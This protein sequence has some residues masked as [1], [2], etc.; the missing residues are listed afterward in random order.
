[1]SNDDVAV[2]GIKPEDFLNLDQRQIEEKLDNAV[3]RY[4]DDCQ[5]L[6]IY[7]EWLSKQVPKLGYKSALNTSHT[8]RAGCDYLSARNYDKGVVIGAFWRHRDAYIR[9]HPGGAREFNFAKRDI[10]INYKKLPTAAP[11]S[12]IA[13][14]LQ[15]DQSQSN[16]P[17]KNVKSPS[18]TLAT[19]KSNVQC[20]PA[21]IDEL[22]YDLVIR[23]RLDKVRSDNNMTF[24]PSVPPKGVPPDS[25]TCR[26]C[27][28]IQNCKTNGNPSFD[29]KPPKGYI[30]RGCGEAETHFV[31]ACP[32][33]SS[34]GPAKSAGSR[35]RKKS[36]SSK[37]ES[38]K[39]LSVDQRPRSGSVKQSTPPSSTVT[40]CR[41]TNA[42]M[43]RQ[44]DVFPERRN[45][46]RSPPAQTPKTRDD[47][48]SEDRARYIQY[49]TDRY[50]PGRSASPEIQPLVGGGPL[51]SGSNTDPIGR[52]P[53]RDSYR[54]LD[55][56]RPSSKVAEPASSIKMAKK[57]ITSTKKQPLAPDHSNG[58]A[59]DGRLSPWDDMQ[60]PIKKRIREDSPDVQGLPWDDIQ[61]PPKKRLRDGSDV[62]NSKASCT[63]AQDLFQNHKPVTGVLEP[64]AVKP[65]AADHHAAE[66]DAADADV[67]EADIM[68]ADAM[69]PNAMEAGATVAGSMEEGLEEDFV[70]FSSSDDY[71]EPGFD[72]D[73]FLAGVERD[74][75][76][77]SCTS[78]STSSSIAQDSDVGIDQN[79]PLD[80]TEACISPGSDIPTQQNRDFTN[81]AADSPEFTNDNHDGLYS[82]ESSISCDTQFQSPA[83]PTLGE[84]NDNAVMTDLLTDTTCFRHSSCGVETTPVQIIQPFQ[85]LKPLRRDPPYDRHVLGLFRG[86]EHAHVYVNVL[87]RRNAIDMYE[88]N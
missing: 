74:L 88:A 15:K 22:K 40:E 41:S 29:C 19:P 80:H 47:H 27:H 20:N 37:T 76:Y 14:S 52:R 35:S 73:S 58:R 68:E 30:C 79:Y 81:K 54:K 43:P 75:W 18:P 26:R 64:Y 9:N 42:R 1:M 62:S 82:L 56:Y 24:T 77:R 70:P 21:T 69:E 16:G 6:D 34:S 53:R 32:R 66:V 11:A 38:K 45:R 49:H 51:R 60:P 85:T 46:S 55:S 2:L 17:V 5:L 44:G 57:N 87:R 33:F 72:A 25:Y 23:E 63:P 65:D 12:S 48:M 28:Y 59:S 67:M 71:D 50:R 13:P 31:S 86:R 7:A 10:E 3:P 8:I 78:A 4:I 36:K 84:Y 39:K 83:A 61:T